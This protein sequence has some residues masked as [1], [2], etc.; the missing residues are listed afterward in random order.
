MCS[1]EGVDKS[2]AGHAK[3]VSAFMFLGVTCL[4]CEGYISDMIHARG[5]EWRARAKHCNSHRP[6]NKTVLPGSKQM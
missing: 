4:I 5:L 6:T 2:T 3:A 1:G